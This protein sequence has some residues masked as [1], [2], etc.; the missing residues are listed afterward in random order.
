MAQSSPGPRIDYWDGFEPETM[1]LNNGAELVDGRLR[2]TNLEGGSQSRSAYHTEQVAV[3][4][5]VCRFQMRNS[6]I[7][8]SAAG[9]LTFIFQ[10]KGAD[11]VG[12]SI[13]TGSTYGYRYN[14]GLPNAIGPS[15]V[16]ELAGNEALDLR[17]V[18]EQ[19]AVQK[20]RGTTLRPELPGYYSG[21]LYD[22]LLSYDGERMDMVITDVDTGASFYQHYLL[23]VLAILGGAT[24]W[25]GFTASTGS[26]DE[27]RVVRCIEK[28]AYWTESGSLP[29]RAEFSM[30]L[31][32]PYQSLEGNILRVK[33]PFIAELDAGMSR[34]LDGSVE[35]YHWSFG[36]GET[37]SGGK[38][39]AT[40]SYMEPGIYPIR[41]Q[42]ED[43]AGNMSPVFEY[44]IEVNDKVQ[45]RIHVTRHS[46]VAPLAVHFDGTETQGLADGDV[47][48]AR[49]SWDFDLDDT[50]PDGRYEQ[51]E[52]FVAAHVF[53]KPGTYRVRLQVTD[54]EGENSVAAT[55]IEVTGSDDFTSYYFASDGDDAA[56]G[57]LE[58][59]KRTLKHAFEELAGPN[60]RTL[61]KRGDVWELDDDLR[62]TAEGPMIVDA[63]TDPEDPSE[64]LP[65]L[66]PTWT[67]AAW[68]A[69]SVYGEDIRLCNFSMN[70][71]GNSVSNP[72][73]P[74]GIA[75]NGKMNLVSGVSF[76]QLGGQ[77]IPLSGYGN[78]MYDCISGEKV[79]PYFSFLSGARK[80]AFIGNDVTTENDYWEHVIR[81]QPA[82][83]GYLA[84]NSFFAKSS[85]S[86]VQFRGQSSQMVVYDNDML[87]RTSAVNPQNDDNEEYAHDVLWEANRFRNELSYKDIPGG[88]LDN[89]CIGVVGRHV[90]VRNNTAENY[91]VIVSA[92]SHPWVGESVN[93]QVYN[94]TVYAEPDAS[95]WYGRL[96]T[97]RNT[98]HAVLRSNLVFS[99]TSEEPVS[100]NY[101]V[102][103]DEVAARTL[104]ADHN[105]YCS[106]TRNL[107]TGFFIVDGVRR[108][109][110]EWR[111]LGY[112]EGSLMGVDPG[113]LS[114]EH[115]NPEFLRLSSV[116]G[117]VDTGNEE[118]AIFTD[119]AGLERPLDGDKNRLSISD[120][121]AYEYLNPEADSDQDGIPDGAE[122]SAGTSLVIPVV[123]LKLQLEGRPPEVLLAFPTESGFFYCLEYT[124]DLSL[125]VQWKAVESGVIAGIGGEVQVL[126]TWTDSVNRRFYRV[127]VSETQE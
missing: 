91:Q 36:D 71:L 107:E 120:I 2:L 50:D 15:L 60:T 115:E 81:C 27:R 19:G 20:I 10:R 104:V 11:A 57:T 87:G 68:R 45:A 126:D 24:A 116:S 111:S 66:V 76:T 74:G 9:G 16:L 14:S 43:N 106:P 127:R 3:D 113:L 61:L 65:R 92:E 8:D 100:W 105:L 42:V 47:V 114:V 125:P 22:F 112:G 7:G 82:Y 99:N 56:P 89:F 124:E 55:E 123:N 78:V 83:Q 88:P 94:N 97:I 35:V 85:K 119:Q 5:F 49:F 80:F 44:I 37:L 79:G 31:R 59:P 95:S 32:S 73:Y 48:N 84:H 102:N 33:G 52:G 41:L 90:T 70:S 62:I 39:Q 72:R 26:S 53:E 6:N 21:H 109:F 46:G 30:G 96:A 29:P 118:V 54:T 34:D 93:V 18:D 63:Y 58:Q 121:G 25:V 110:Q 98:H 23:D 86:N 28:W 77:C 64:E 75:L 1:M 12:D 13:S 117:A 4:R 38:A 51:G 122:L 108:S 69:V 103:I 40:H 17:F 101:M 67:D